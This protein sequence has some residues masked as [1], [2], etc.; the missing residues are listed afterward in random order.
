MTNE[1]KHSLTEGV[2]VIIP[3]YNSRLILP[4]LVRRIEAVLTGIETN[5]ELI[6]VDDGSLDESWFAVRELAKTRGWVR[7]IRMMRNY[8]QH[9]ALLAG[10]REARFHVTV[11]MD[12]DLQHPPEEL[13]RLLKKCSEGYDVLY[14]PP[15]TD[16]HGWP[17][18][19][20]SWITKVT[21]QNVMGATTAR[22]VSDK[23]SGIPS[24]STFITLTYGCGGLWGISWVYL[25]IAALVWPQSKLIRFVARL[26]FSAKSRQFSLMKYN[27]AG[28]IERE[29]YLGLSNGR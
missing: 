24:K 2:S 17:R 14:A 23:D 13:P 21:L 15:E 19:I 4:E 25:L 9:N 20:A 3:V 5:Y 16:Q 29:R 27:I 1:G 12:D 18:Y 28:G 7:G 22:S 26:P 11:T 8:G 6:L 10:I